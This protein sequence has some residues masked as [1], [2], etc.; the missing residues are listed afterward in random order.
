MTNPR[1]T[2]AKIIQK[3]LEEKIFFGDLKKQISEKDLPFCNM[4]ILTTL[5]RLTALRGILHGFIRKKI[6]HKHRLAEYLLLCALAEI[7]YMQTAEYAVINETV[8][9][10]CKTCDKFLGGMANAVLRSVCAQKSAL[11]QKADSISPLPETFTEILE[12]YSTEQI[13][14]IGESV[15]K[16][17]PLDITVKANPQEW[18]AKMNALMLPNGTLRLFNPPQIRQ[19]PEYSAGTWWVQDFSASLPVMAMGDVCGKKVIDL[20]AAPGGKTAQ[21]LA[22]GAKVTAL[23]ISESRLETLKQNMA[24][25][26]FNDVQTKAIDALEY[27]RNTAEQFDAILLDAPCSATGT[28]RRHPEVLHIK[29]RQDVTEQAN[30]QKELLKACENVLKV[31]GI[32]LYSVCSIAQTEGE[33]QIEEFLQTRKNYKIV[34]IK[35]QEIAPFGILADSPIMPNGTVRVMPYYLNEQN[36]ADSF[37]IC[38]MQRII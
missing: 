18:V 27:L 9:D 36:G 1:L 29:N 33:R 37:F 17:P 6:P 30:L 38:K 8:K 22:K 12:G 35:P 32:L 21:L 26:G 34:P 24:R 2:C 25:L 3:I 31:G 16:I 15:L 13:R 14:L 5:R 7:L 19:L 28:F 23:D 4:L 10:I 20:C 11:W